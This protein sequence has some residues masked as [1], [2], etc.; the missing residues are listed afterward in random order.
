MRHRK[1]V[2]EFT[3]P[4]SAGGR[5]SYCT[6]IGVGPAVLTPSYPEVSND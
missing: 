3:R 2:L 4:G 6:A 5:Y 1:Y